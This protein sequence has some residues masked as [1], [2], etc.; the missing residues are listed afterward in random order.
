MGLASLFSRFRRR[1]LPTALAVALLL[2]AG[3]ASQPSP[4]AA[5]FLLRTPPGSAAA[6]D[7]ASG[8]PPPALHRDGGTHDANDDANDDDDDDERDDHDAAQTALK[9]GLIAPLS[10]ILVQVRRDAPGTVLET[11]LESHGGR[12]F[13]E[14]MVLTPRGAVWKLV[15]DARTGSLVR[16]RGHGFSR[17]RENKGR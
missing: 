16:G 13:Y 4:A 2:A 15:Y 8:H 9:A 6:A 7:R 1:V 11:E 5:G 17:W 12:W 10:D 3:L 14:I